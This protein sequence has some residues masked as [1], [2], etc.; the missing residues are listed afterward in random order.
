MAEKSMEFNVYDVLNPWFIWFCC[1]KFSISGSIVAHW[2]G[3]HTQPE[4]GVVVVDVS[5]VVDVIKLCVVC[6]TVVDAVA[7]SVEPE[8]KIIITVM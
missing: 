7:G 6:G 5:L 2:D 4:S 3:V 8:S 1:T